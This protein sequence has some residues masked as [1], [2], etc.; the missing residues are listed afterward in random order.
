L[1]PVAGCDRLVAMCGVLGWGQHVRELSHASIERST[2]LNTCTY[3]YI[4]IYICIRVC[5]YTYMYIYNYRYSYIRV[6]I[7]IDI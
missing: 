1:P 6:D 4:Y 5:M 2:Q 3:I 7:G